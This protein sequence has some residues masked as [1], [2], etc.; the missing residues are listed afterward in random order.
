MIATYNYIYNEKGLA[1]YVVLPVKIWEMLKP[2]LN[3]NEIKI[4]EVVPN[5]NPEKFNPREFFGAISHLNIDIEE[6]L[7]NMRSEWTRNF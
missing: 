7:K 5:P 6:E 1:E 3:S 4:N 2:Y